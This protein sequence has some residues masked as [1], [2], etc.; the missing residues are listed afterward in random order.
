MGRT[1]GDEVWKT[2]LKEGITKHFVNEIVGVV[3]N[4]K[5]IL[6]NTFFVA[7]YFYFLEDKFPQHYLFSPY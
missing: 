3:D 5:K 1:K 7:V 2:I 4:S 6:G